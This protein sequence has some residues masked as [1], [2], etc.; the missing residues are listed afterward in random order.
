[1]EFEFLDRIP[2]DIP[3]ALEQLGGNLHTVR[4]GLPELVKNSKDQ[5]SYLGVTDE[6]LRQIVVLVNTEDQKLAVLDFAGATSDDLAGWRTWSSRR[7]KRSQQALDIEA[8]HGNGGKFFM[9]L[10]STSQSFIESCFNGMRNKMGY[11]NDDSSHKY[12]PAYIKETGHRIQDLPE[13]HPE[14][15][16]K[17]VLKEFGIGIAGLPP[18]CQQVF[19]YR[20]SFTIVQLDGVS[21]W[22]GKWAKKIKEHALNIP[23]E[24]SSHGQAALAIA[25]CKIW[26]IVDEKL[27]NKKPLEIPVLKPFPG[28]ETPL[29]IAVPDQLFDPKD[30]TQVNTGEGNK[31]LVLRTSERHLRL[32]E[33]TKAFNIVR[34]KNER[35]VVGYWT[36]AELAPL[37]AS[38]FLYGELQL[39]AMT[40]EHT[41]GAEWERFKDT[42]LVRAV[43]VWVSE[44]VNDLAQRIQK[45]M[46]KE[47][48]PE[49]RGKAN[50]VLSRFRDLMREYLDADASGMLGSE[51]L[52]VGKE[53]AKPQPPKAPKEWGNK[54]DTILLEPN[55]KS[56]AIALGSRVPLEFKCYEN[57]GEERL[58]VKD[59]KVDLIPNRKGIVKFDSDRSIT[60]F[61]AGKIIAKLRDRGTGVESNEMEMEVVACSEVDLAGPDEPILQGQHVEIL[62]SF[63]TADGNRD[64][65]LIDAAVDDPNV[66]KITRKGFFTAAYQEGT[67]MVQVRF[68]P[69]PLDYKSLSVIVGP[70][71]IPVRGSGG[72]DIPIVLLCGTEAPGMEEYPKD[73]RTHPG[74]DRYPTIIEEPPFFNVVWINLHSKEAQK[75]GRPKGGP[76]GIGG[77]ATS[78]S[79]QF[80]ALKCFDILKRLVVRQRLGSQSVT[81]REFTRSLGQ[82]ETDCATFIEGAYEIAQD[83]LQNK[84]EAA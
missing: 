6:N 51:G 36:V 25:S 41:I 72:S 71:A 59:A 13:S 23:V 67:A 35:N 9:V 74:G 39:P 44:H 70:E 4:D 33:E 84:K 65:L 62:H 19:A 22:Q 53:G 55:R 30:Q 46:E 27:T 60:G 56:I 11:K 14:K 15:R 34:V 64:D 63:R 20:K 47:V 45:K 40:S 78:S 80:L 79:F 76:A 17:A 1:M 10:G 5:Y 38:A 54:V 77:I 2:I 31:K 26:V 69:G 43:K 82:A 16:L 66:G 29:E 68:G 58:P 81:E 7:E 3:R 83:L 48:R 75:A 18:A 42:P 49:E 61:S 37:A 57:Q 52:G 73:Q 28:F 50:E 12:F 24:L 21:N 8:T 32:S